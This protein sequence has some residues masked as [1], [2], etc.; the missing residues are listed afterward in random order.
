MSIQSS[1]KVSV[2]MFSNRTS[3][4]SNKDY[5]TI[6]I[7]GTQNPAT[8]HMLFDYFDGAQSLALCSCL[9]SQRRFHLPV[10][11][12]QHQH[13]RYGKQPDRCCI[14]CRCWRFDGDQD[15]DIVS[16]TPT[17][18]VRSKTV[19]QVDG[20]AIP[21]TDLSPSPTPPFSTTIWTW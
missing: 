11:G 13:H 14:R 17:A 20:T 4:F 3:A 1:G 10:L 12:D 2:D 5:T 19:V 15:L 16:S 8:T 21:T 6:N 7:A 18:T 9:S